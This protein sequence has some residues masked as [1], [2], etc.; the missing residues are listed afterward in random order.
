MILQKSFY[1]ADLLLIIFI[2]FINI[3]NS[4]A[5]LMFVWKLFFDK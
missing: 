3:E 2:I 1:Y 5:A 4:C